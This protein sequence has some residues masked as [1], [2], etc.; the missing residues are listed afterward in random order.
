MLSDSAMA[1]V[2]IAAVR[3]PARARLLLDIL[4]TAPEAVKRKADRHGPL[5]FLLLGQGPLQNRER[6]LL[7]SFGQEWLR[8]DF[9]P[10]ELADALE[11][12]LAEVTG[13]RL[14]HGRWTAGWRTLAGRRHGPSLIQPI[15]R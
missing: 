14:S 8:G 10:R 7:D 12:A 1:A 11:R 15:D 2:R 13:H 9:G 4:R 6:R 5:G 3:S